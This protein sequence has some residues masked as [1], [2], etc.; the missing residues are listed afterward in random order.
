MRKQLTYKIVYKSYLMDELLAAF[1]EWLVGEGEDRRCLLFMSMNDER[2]GVKL[3]VPNEADEK[4]I[5]AVVL[6]HDPNKPT[7]Y[8]ILRSKIKATAKS[9]EGV[10]LKDLTLG[11]IKA[12]LAVMLWKAG[13]VSDDMTINKLGEWI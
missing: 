3:I 10:L 1:P 7:E 5:E 4:A 2:D 9:A 6:A 12:L 11:Q 13:G 8:E